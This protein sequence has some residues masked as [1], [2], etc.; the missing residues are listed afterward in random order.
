MA[1]FQSNQLNELT[2]T[3]SIKNTYYLYMKYH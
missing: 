3:N 2:I 1:E